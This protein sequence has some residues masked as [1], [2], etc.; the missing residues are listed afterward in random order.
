[1]DH[2]LI[3]WVNE[4]ENLKSLLFESLHEW[5]SSNHS[6]ALTSDVIDI[7]LIFFHSGDV[8]LEGNLILS[9]FGSAESEEIS[10]L[11]SVGG[12]L[13]DTEFQV[14]G[15]LLIELFVVLLVFSNF[16]E[17]F[18]ALLDDV[19]LEDIRILFCGRVSL[20]MLS[21]RSLESTIPLTN[22]SHSG[23]R[24]SQSSMIKTLLT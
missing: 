12:V 22:E 15:E 23:M 8:V 24:S 19:L 6:F 13:M 5:G 4:I 16:S 17:H 2:V 21:G 3:D 18:K 14:L 7:F 10:N 11:L 9:R 20:E 1:L